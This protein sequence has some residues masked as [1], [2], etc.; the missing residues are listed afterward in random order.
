MRKKLNAKCESQGDGSRDAKDTFYV[1]DYAAKC[2]KSRA[3]YT[4]G[5]DEEE[6]G[7]GKR[8]RVSGAGKPKSEACNTEEDK[9]VYCTC[10]KKARGF[11]IGCDKCDEWF[12][13][14]CVGLTKEE[15]SQLTSYTCPTCAHKGEAWAPATQ[16]DEGTS[17]GT[18]DSQ[19]ADTAHTEVKEVLEGKGNARG[20]RSR[21]SAD[22]GH[23]GATDGPTDKAAAGHVMEVLGGGTGGS[24]QAEDAAAAGTE[25]GRRGRGQVSTAGTV[26]DASGMKQVAGPSGEVSPAEMGGVVP[27]PGAVV[28]SK[29]GAHVLSSPFPT[30]SPVTATTRSGRQ[31]KASRWKS[32]RE[33]AWEV[34]MGGARGWKGEE[35]A[36]GGCARA[37][38]DAAVV[39]DHNA[40][41]GAEFADRIAKG[42]EGEGGAKLRV[43]VDTCHKDRGDGE[44]GVAEAKG[45]ATQG[46][47]IKGART[48]RVKQE[49]KEEGAEKSDKAVKAKALPGAGKKKA[50]VGAGA[51]VK[52]EGGNAEGVK[53]EGPAHK[54]SSSSSPSSSSRSSDVSPASSSSS[55]SSS[56]STASGSSSDADSGPCPNR[57]PGERTEGAGEGE[58]GQKRRRSLRR[59]RAKRSF[60]PLPSSSSS[61]DSGGEGASDGESMDSEDDRYSDDVTTYCSCRRIAF[62]FMLACD[63]CGEWFHGRCVGVTAEVSCADGFGAGQPARARKE[64]GPKRH[65]HPYPPHK[66]KPSPKEGSLPKGGADES[67]RKKLTKKPPSASVGGPAVSTCSKSAASAPKDAIDPT[68]R[69]RVCQGLAGALSALAG[70][71]MDADGRTMAPPK[72]RDVGGRAHEAGRGS[73]E[74]GSSA[75]AVCA[76]GRERMKAGESAHESGTDAADGRYGAGAVSGGVPAAGGGRHGAVAGA[77]AGAV[78]SS[79]VSRIIVG[80]DAAFQELAVRVEKELFALLHRQPREYKTRYRS[81]LFNLKDPHNPEL[82]QRVVDGSITPYELCRMSTDQMAS[83]E[84]TLWRSKK[85][86]EAEKAVVITEAPTQ[87]VKKTH[88]GEETLVASAPHEGGGGPWR[89]GILPR[90]QRSRWG[91]GVPRGCVADVGITAR[92]AGVTGVRAS[93]G[94]GDGY[95]AATPPFADG[96]ALFYA[97]G[98]LGR[99]ELSPRDFLGG[100]GAAGGLGY[101]LM[102]R[103]EGGDD[104]EDGGMGRDG[105]S[106]VPPGAEPPG[107]QAHGAGGN[108]PDTPVLGQGAGGSL[109]IFSSDGAVEEQGGKQGDRR[110]GGSVAGDAADLRHD[111][112]LDQGVAG[113][114]RG[115]ETVLLQGGLVHGK[116]LWCGTLKR[117]SSSA[118]GAGDVLQVSLYCSKSNHSLPPM[119][120]LFPDDTLHIKGRVELATLKSYIHTLRASHR[121]QLVL[122]SVMPFGWQNVKDTPG[123]QQVSMAAQQLADSLKSRDR[124]GLAHPRDGVEVYLVPLCSLVYS[125]LASE[126]GLPLPHAL[127]AALP[128]ATTA[129]TEGGAGGTSPV[130]DNPSRIE[131]FPPLVRHPPALVGLLV[132]KRDAFG[133]VAPSPSGDRGI[134]QQPPATADIPTGPGRDSPSNGEGSERVGRSQAGDS[135]AERRDANAVESN[136]SGVRG[137]APHVASQ[138]AQGAH[139]AAWHGDHAS[140]VQPGVPSANEE[141]A[142]APPGFALPGGTPALA[143][144]DSP[145]EPPSVSMLPPHQV[146]DPRQVSPW[147]RPSVPATTNP[148][149]SPQ[150]G[151]T[152]SAV[153][154][155]GAHVSSQPSSQP[156][157]SPGGPAGGVV[158]AC[159]S[160]QAPVGTPPDG[161]GRVDAPLHLVG[162][163]ARGAHDPRVPPQDPP[164]RA[165]P[166]AAESALPARQGAVIG[167]W[168]EPR[169]VG[170][171]GAHGQPQPDWQGAHAA[172]RVVV[173]GPGQGLPSGGAGGVVVGGPGRATPPGF[174][175]PG[176][177]PAG[178]ASSGWAEHPPPGSM[179]TPPVAWG[180]GR[181]PGARDQPWGHAHGGVG[182]SVPGAASIPAAS[183]Y[184]EG[185]GR[186]RGAG[187]GVG[188]AAWG[189]PGAVGMS[190][191][192]GADVALAAAMASAAATAMGIRPPGHEGGRAAVAGPGV[193][194]SSGGLWQGGNA[195]TGARPTAGWGPNQVMPPVGAG[196]PDGRQVAAGPPPPP[197]GEGL[198][199]HRGGEGGAPGGMNVSGGWGGGM[200]ERRRDPWVADPAWQSHGGYGAPGQVP[201]A[202]MGQQGWA[203]AGHAGS[204]GWEERDRGRGDAAAPAAPGWGSQGGAQ[205][206][207]DRWHQPM[208]VGLGPGTPAGDLHCEGQRA[209]SAGWR[210]SGE[211]REGDHSPG[212]DRSG[213]VQ[214]A[215]GGG[216]PP[217]GPGG[218]S[219]TDPN[220]PGDA[221]WANR[222]MGA[223]GQGYGHPGPNLDPRFQ[224][225]RGYGE[226]GQSALGFG[227]ERGRHGRDRGGPLPG[228]P[229]TAQL[230]SGRGGMSSQGDGHGPADPRQRQQGW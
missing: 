67:M 129:I 97:G 51:R 19:R 36:A 166:V 23:S 150:A 179:G 223:P 228:P 126:G 37:S 80:D 58:V 20:G 193:A 49:V 201:R 56:S 127:M 194:A 21:K 187:V 111:A 152:S 142:A 143:R 221:N 4:M 110:T 137:D 211:R 104:D 170:G 144:G 17:L 204:G 103:D 100:H 208:G 168:M 76:D 214:E 202:G 145:S 188:V 34:D 118:G 195:G 74:L 70:C 52:P 120:L 83:S 10:R 186:A 89:G 115:A 44:G 61:S 53:P 40:G 219:R 62:G 82:R 130:A 149:P 35:V 174:V 173:G 230:P 108:S 136:G 172:A 12:H 222:G 57:D 14:K 198:W 224:G 15:G 94:R 48:K 158:G 109:G 92:V 11:M 189:G 33:F 90:G 16:R 59:R 75:R 177:A 55:S 153:T 71:A 121:R 196:L 197:L 210:G 18:R 30:V 96:D 119:E 182:S 156:F 43:G 181:G 171:P 64:A 47:A 155:G 5:Q 185:D 65:P 138:G 106:R 46:K 117:P 139:A 154:S 102:D 77:G 31:V 24:S 176:V 84:L 7:K 215:W 50:R 72:P 25:E 105:L 63:T 191:V 227:E 199:N 164:A 167:L 32:D 162:R 91:G 225:E 116:M 148:P 101:D 220:A 87:W 27:L 93:A 132:I 175:R 216:R 68:I 135:Q 165:S 212:G 183:G 178:G 98:D 218:H 99:S 161:S 190:S 78:D 160:A 141:D 169:G 133:D 123:A 112:G 124:A 28:P 192:G 206:M 86:E 45:S 180:P 217:L 200:E 159:A 69:H 22:K 13:G 88:K 73:E 2:G 131:A 85:L 209:D 3:F 29:P 203:G 81:L 66:S 213:R 125:L 41:D 122:I 140:S 26:D 205:G 8:K 184:A 146:P 107:A 9:T 151:S 163:R 157:A 42:G 1:T 95:N 39:S 226:G 60:S 147:Q 6:L 79:A 128:T 113:A 54:P 207:A 229:G 114:E 38:W 134:R